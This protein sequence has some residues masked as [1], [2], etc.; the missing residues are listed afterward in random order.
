[1]RGPALVLSPDRSHGRQGADRLG[2]ATPRWRDGKT[3]TAPTI[4]GSPT[5]SPI[6]IPRWGVPRSSSVPSGPPTS[7]LAAA[8]GAD[9]AA[10]RWVA[11]LPATD[12]AGVIDCY[13]Q[14]RQDGELLH[15]VIADRRTDAYLGEVMVLVGEYRVGEFGVGVVAEA[16]GRGIATDAFCT[17][18]AWSL[19]ALD[20]RRLQVLVAPENAGALQIARRA[21]FRREGLLAPTGSMRASD[22]TPSCCRGSPTTW[23]TSHRRVVPESPAPP[24]PP[25]RGSWPSPPRTRPR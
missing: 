4:A 16:R 21:G 11:P 2:P 25:S 22:P 6:R 3:A 8:F 5:R 18:V 9:P 19:T 17:F 23:S 7:T 24:T 13:E 14:Y 15:L 10:A 1:M 20:I 12:P